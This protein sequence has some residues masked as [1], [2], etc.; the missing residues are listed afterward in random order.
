MHPPRFLAFSYRSVSCGQ[1]RNQHLLTFSEARVCT[2]AADLERNRTFDDVS[3]RRPLTL[4]SFALQ[5]RYGLRQLM[6]SEDDMKLE[7]DGRWRSAYA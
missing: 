1:T 3:E 2:P 7:R 5:R 6:T 4:S